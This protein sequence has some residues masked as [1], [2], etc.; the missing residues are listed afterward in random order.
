MALT[1]PAKNKSLVQAT[2][3]PARSATGGGQKPG[4]DPS[5]EQQLPSISGKL[6]NQQSSHNLK[7]LAWSRYHEASSP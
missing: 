6:A 4:G 5:P 2:A 1:E 7:L 3:R